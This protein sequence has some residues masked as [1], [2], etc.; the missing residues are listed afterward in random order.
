M[1]SPLLRLAWPSV[2]ASA[3]GVE[4]PLGDEEFEVETAVVETAADGN[5]V[6]WMLELVGSVVEKAE[7][8]SD[9]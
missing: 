5:D 3:A 9:S 1:A 2:S 8:A 7:S 4:N 6:G